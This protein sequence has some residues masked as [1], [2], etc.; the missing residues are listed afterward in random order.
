VKKGVKKLKKIKKRQLPPTGELKMVN[1]EWENYGGR[2]R[3]FQNTT[4]SVLNSQ[5]FIPR[6]G[7]PPPQKNPPVGR[8]PCRGI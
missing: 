4:F 5:F 7:N 8:L 3:C 6:K 1:G 2:T